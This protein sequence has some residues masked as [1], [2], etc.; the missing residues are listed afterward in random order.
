MLPVF[1]AQALVR[2]ELIVTLRMHRSY[3][4]LVICVGAAIAVLYVFYPD[5]QQ[6][7]DYAPG[8]SQRIVAGIALALGC[9]ATLFLPSLAGSAITLEKETENF[10]LLFLTLIKPRGILAAKLVNVMGFF[11]LLMTGILP[12]LAGVFFLT[13]V[14]WGYV[15]NL[16]IQIT[17]VAL[18]CSA[19]GLLFSALFRRT[20]YALIASYLGLLLVFGVPILFVGW[21][22]VL[23]DWLRVDWLLFGRSVIPLWVRMCY[24]VFQMICPVYILG[25]PAARV[26][27]DSTL[28]ATLYQLVLTGAALWLA[29]RALRRPPRPPKVDAEKPIDDI[30]LL[31]ARRKQFPYYLIDPRR[32]KR[33]IEDNR[34]PVF[35]KEYR[36]GLVGRASRLVRLFYVSLALFLVLTAT[37][38]IFV[39]SEVSRTGIDVALAWPMMLMTGLICL[40]TPALQANT[41]TKEREQGNLDMLRMT[42]VRPHEIVFGKGAACL[43]A[44]LPLLASATLMV[45]LLF[46]LILLW[47][48]TPRV[49]FAGGGLLYVCVIH[50]VVCSL[51]ASLLTRRTTSAL[52][53][54]YTMVLFSFC[55]LYFLANAAST[56]FEVFQPETG[57]GM[58][59]GIVDQ[60]PIQQRMRLD[61]LSPFVAF[62]AFARRGRDY[63]AYASPLQVD[64]TGHVVRS[65]ILLVLTGFGLLAFS[66]WKFAKFNMR[67]R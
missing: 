42:M 23:F 6:L 37:T 67:D 33:L 55:G 56:Y 34:N 46:A 4:A 26:S 16:V 27:A 50:T 32:R 53:L 17:L 8:V 45:C 14:D 62:D 39:V 28:Y 64:F 54:S 25:G 61:V 22:L 65:L 9:A 1:P 2:R 40:I 30:A 49:V 66:T 7:R 58:M 11:L 5:A 29:Q 44:I 13:G 36:W 48:E 3:L 24:E 41:F 59:G 31:E 35:V 21:F 52:L 10:D 12:V 20:M 43:F 57:Y 38:V 60:S 63:Y 15:L 51:S 47:R 18:S 19:L